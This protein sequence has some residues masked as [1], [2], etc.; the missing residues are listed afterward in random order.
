VRAFRIILVLLPLLGGCGDIVGRAGGHPAVVGVRLLAPDGREIA[1][2]FRLVAGWP[3]ELEVRFVDAGG[4]DIEGLEVEHR[5]RLDWNPAG[6]VVMDTVSG[7]PFRRRLRLLRPCGPHGTL[8]V[9]YGHTPFADEIRFGPF[10]VVV[11]NPITSVRLF[12][13]EGVEITDSIPLVPD[14]PL[15][16]EVRFYG[17]DGEPVTTFGETDEMRVFWSSGDLGADAP[18]TGARFTRRLW[19]AA[20]AGTVG[21]LSI[22][23]G[24]GPY[25]DAQVFGPFRVVVE[26]PDEP[27]EGAEG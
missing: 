24:R 14:E 8:T 7:E 21:T 1:G 12:D 26:E 19:T 22:G 10:P 20:P 23:F 27:E 5:T 17:C 9:G 6:V 13:P 25:P 15:E 4:N 18:V 16:M 3:N 2:P 11:E